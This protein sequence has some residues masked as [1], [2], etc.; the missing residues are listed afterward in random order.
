MAGRIEIARGDITR[1]AVDAIVNAA[2]TALARG[3]GVCGAIF[4]AAGPGLEEECRRLGGCPTGEAR[5]TRGH[6]LAAKWVIHTPGP[7]WEG[8]GSGEAALLASCYRSSLA[9]AAEHGA[10]TVGFPS[11]STGIYGFPVDR[12]CRIALREI[13]RGLERHPGLTSVT[14]VCFDEATLATYREAERELAA[15]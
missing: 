6:G 4:R 14:V 5:I 1:L 8:G 10:R 3:G 12:A 9:L 13:A 7:V 15:T 2:N 11:I